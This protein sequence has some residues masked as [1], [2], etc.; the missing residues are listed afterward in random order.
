MCNNGN[1]NISIISTAS[2]RACTH[3][4][5]DPEHYRKDGTCRCN[6]SSHTEMGEWGYKWN[7]EKWISPEDGE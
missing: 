6:D 7:G 5:F 4:I 3:F 1:N 2:I